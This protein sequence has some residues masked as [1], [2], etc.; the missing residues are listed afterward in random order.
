MWWGV[1]LF[2]VA[3]MPSK[4]WLIAGAV[5]NTLLFTFVSIPMAEQKQAKKEGFLEYKK[6]TRILFPIK[7]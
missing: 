1:G 5:I 7:K 3:L 4:W 6:E 2:S